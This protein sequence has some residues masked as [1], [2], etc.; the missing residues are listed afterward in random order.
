MASVERGVK[1]NFLNSVQGFWPEQVG[2]VVCHLLRWLRPM[3]KE[4]GGRHREEGEEF[5]LNRLGLG[6]L[7]DLALG[8]PALGVRGEMG[9]GGTTLWL[10]AYGWHLKPG[11]WMRY[12]TL[13]SIALGL[14][15]Q[16]NVFLIKK[17]KMLVVMSYM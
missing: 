8:F 15:S 16:W 10:S 1:D 17:K 11:H 12:L 14:P 2:R 4:S 13:V 9:H 3:G 5:G 7:L 6:C